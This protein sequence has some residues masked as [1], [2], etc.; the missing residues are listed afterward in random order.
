M[1][2]LQVHIVQDLP[3]EN[4]SFFVVI[5]VLYVKAFLGHSRQNGWIILIPRTWM[6][7]DFQIVKFYAQ[8]YRGENDYTI[9]SAENV[10]IKLEKIHF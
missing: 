9:L 1:I 3:S 2:T 5:K 10:Y 8:L 4:C 7:Q 6:Q